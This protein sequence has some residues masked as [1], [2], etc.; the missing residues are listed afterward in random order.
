MP[1]ESVPRGQT[2]PFSKVKLE[3]CVCVHIVHMGIGGH[4]EAGVCVFMWRPEVDIRHFLQSL[5]ISLSDPDS[6]PI[7]SWAGQ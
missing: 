6:H 4:M 2:M 5:S 3:V 7:W 1:S